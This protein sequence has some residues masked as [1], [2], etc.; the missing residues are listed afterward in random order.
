MNLTPRPRHVLALAL[1]AG[2]GLAAC[3]DGAAPPDL[4]RRPTPALPT[5][6]AAA[7]QVPAI[8]ATAVAAEPAHSVVQL[9]SVFADEGSPA[10]ARI[11]IWTNAEGMRRE[12]SSPDSLYN[13]GVV[14]V[15]DLDTISRYNPSTKIFSRNARGVLNIVDQP[16]YAKNL[17]EKSQF[18]EITEDTVDGKPAIRLSGR[19]EDDPLRRDAPT[20]FTVWLDAE[21]HLIVKTQKVVR[22]EIGPPFAVTTRVLAYDP[23]EDAARFKLEPPADA[24]VLVQDSVAN[25]V[26]TEPLSLEEARKAVT[27]PLLT[28]SDLPEDITL[29]S[30]S[31]SKPE[32][33][34]GIE[35]TV[36]QFYVRDEKEGYLVAEQFSADAPGSARAKARRELALKLG[37]SVTVGEHDGVYVDRLG[38]RYVVWQTDKTRVKLSANRPDLDEAALLEWAGKMR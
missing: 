33:G 29:Y 1:I 37:K 14:S 15:D 2:V 3:K 4:T 20:D 13:P 21:T 25:P 30:T 23:P 7:A 12:E 31:V 32:S 8:V 9:E 17:L 19:P 6:T 28:L 34:Q 35:P 36:I 26:T 18:G 11:T 10:I 22:S 5:L 38:T 24:D 16:P 27:Y